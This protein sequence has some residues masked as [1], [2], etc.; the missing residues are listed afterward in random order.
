MDKTG[1]SDHYRC[2]SFTEQRDSNEEIHIWL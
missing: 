2:K 1:S